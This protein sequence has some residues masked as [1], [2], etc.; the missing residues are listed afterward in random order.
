MIDCEAYSDSYSDVPM[1]SVVG[2]AFAVHPD[3]QL[4][5]LASMYGWAV[6]DLK[7]ASHGEASTGA[8]A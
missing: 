7:A 6:L 4:R 8:R 2:R 3:A 1:L 5:K